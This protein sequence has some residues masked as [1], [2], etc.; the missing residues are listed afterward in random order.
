MDRYHRVERPRPE[1]AIEENE[2][3]ITAQG[4][5]RNYVSYATS[6]LQDRRIKEIVL[7]AMGQAISKSVAVAEIIKKRVPGLYQ[8]TNISS[9]SITDV[10]EPIEEGLTRDDSP[11]FD[12]IN[13]LISQR[14]GQEFSWF[15]L[16]SPGNSSVSSRHHHHHSAKFVNHHL[17]MKTTMSEVVAEEGAVDV[18]GVGVEEA[19]VVMAD[20]E[21]IKVGTTKVVGTMITKV[22]M[23]AMIIREG[24]VAMIIKGGMAVVDM[25]T[26]KADMET[27][28][29]MVD[30][31]E[32]VVAC[33]GGAIGVTVVGM[34]V[35]EVAVF[36]VE[37]DMVVVDEEEWV[38][39]A[40]VETEALSSEQMSGENP[41][42][43]GDT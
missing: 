27:T 17:I 13:Y 36:L 7:K 43:T 11:C 2:I 6:L 41:W 16:N 22:G 37:G 35:A 5:I 4:L 3:R 38:P 33:A 1:S 29:K 28:K 12:D 10:W 20:M 39:V 25:A 30:I 24:M 19:M 32:D 23:V 40:D 26:T 31:T 21:T 8:D 42:A 9:V 15:T 14:P 18:E 34:N